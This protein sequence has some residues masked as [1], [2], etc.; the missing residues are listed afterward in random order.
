VVGLPVPGSTLNLKGKTPLFGLGSVVLTR[1]D[2]AVVWD[3]CAAVICPL[4]LRVMRQTGPL[5]RA[6]LR[7]DADQAHRFGLDRTVGLI[8]ETRRMIEIKPDAVLVGTAD[9]PTIAAIRR[10]IARASAADRI[11]AGHIAQ[12][13]FFADAFGMPDRCL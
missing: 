10:T 7:L 12:S 4:G 8:V 6:Q 3:L 13:S 1:R 11:E 5:H 2:F 9:G